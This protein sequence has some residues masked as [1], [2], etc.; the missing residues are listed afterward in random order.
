MSDVRPTA[1][2]SCTRRI[3]SI[4]RFG[5]GL[6]DPIF[7]CRAT[8]EDTM[9]VY[10]GRVPERVLRQRQHEFV[11]LL[12]RGVDP[13]EAARQS[14]HPAHRALKTLSELGFTLS[15]LEPEQQAA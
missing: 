1:Y 11:K 15:V 5:D 4:P 9:S 6:T 2:P 3:E 14:G 13:A 7:G 8:R 12:A 10:K